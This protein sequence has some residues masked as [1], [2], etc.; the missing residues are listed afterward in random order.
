MG[1][2]DHDSADGLI[3]GI[4][5]GDGEDVGGAVWFVAEGEIQG[6]IGFFGLVE[7]FGL[8]LATLESGEG[9]SKVLNSPFHDDFGFPIELFFAGL[10]CCFEEERGFLAAEREADGGTVA[11]GGGF[12]E[13][14]VGVALEG[15]GIGISL[16]LVCVRDAA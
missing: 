2:W 11:I 1:D 10:S 13:R 8:G 14:V 9:V 6:A 7:E 12:V 3:G 4:L 15:W 5:A 16:G